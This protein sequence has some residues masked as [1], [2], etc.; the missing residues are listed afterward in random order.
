MVISLGEMPMGDRYG[1]R[2][3]DRLRIT[4]YSGASEEGVAGGDQLED[5][6]R[7]GD[8][9]WRK[10]LEGGTPGSL[11]SSRMGETHSPANSIRKN[12]DSK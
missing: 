9:V 3:M 7:P 1:L 11:P 8:S 6:R 2:D 4:M 12:K 5:Q 10:A